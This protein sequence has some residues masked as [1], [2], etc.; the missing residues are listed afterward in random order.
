MFQRR[1]QNYFTRCS[2]YINCTLLSDKLIDVL[3][4]RKTVQIAAFFCWLLSYNFLGIQKNCITKWKSNISTRW[5]VVVIEE[6]YE[7]EYFKRN[8]Q[9]SI[10]MSPINVH[11]TDT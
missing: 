5:Q 6:V 4:L 10:F 1:S 9:I 7:G 11:V 8:L 2:F 3:W